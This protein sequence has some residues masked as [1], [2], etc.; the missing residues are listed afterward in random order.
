M[1]YTGRKYL[2]TEGKIKIP[3]P[4]TNGIKRSCCDAAE[5]SLAGIK[6]E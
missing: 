4:Y 3:I 6:F 5:N 1:T 2:S